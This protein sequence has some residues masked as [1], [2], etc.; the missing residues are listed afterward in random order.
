MLNKLFFPL[1]ADKTPGPT[2]NA[3]D[4]GLYRWKYEPKFTMPSLLRTG[5]TRGSPGPATYEP[6][7]LQVFKQNHP[8]FTI[9]QRGRSLKTLQTPGPKYK[10]GEALSKTMQTSPA[11][12]HRWRNPDSKRMRTPG[13]NAYDL[14]KYNPFSSGAAFTMAQKAADSQG[15]QILPSDNCWALFDF[16]W[17]IVWRN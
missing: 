12:T 14:T 17:K 4:A 7:S 9:R 5:S 11:F 2:Y 15:V 8:R 10:V 13:A 6:T 16:C 1:D 3:T